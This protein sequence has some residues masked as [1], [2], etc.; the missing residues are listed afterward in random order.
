MLNK[1]KL[2]H[3]KELARIEL[4]EEELEQYARE[5]NQILEYVSSLEKLDLKNVQPMTGGT[6]LQ[7]PLRED[8]PSRPLEE[9]KQIRDKIIILFPDQQDDF[10]KIPPCF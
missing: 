8:K 10:L 2:K 3:L 5:L 7:A 6:V 9:K 4:T 1:E